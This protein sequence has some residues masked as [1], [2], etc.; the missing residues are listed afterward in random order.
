MTWYATKVINV[1]KLEETLQN[2]NDNGH[3][4]FSVVASQGYIVIVSNTSP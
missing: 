1:E 4:I 2:L 3:T